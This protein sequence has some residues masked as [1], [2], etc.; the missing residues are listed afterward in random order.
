[1][2]TLRIYNSENCPTE[3]YHFRYSVYVEEMHRP[4]SDADHDNKLIKDYLDETGHH[5]VV[6]DEG[7]IVGCMRVNFLRDGSYGKYWDFYKLDEFQNWNPQ[8]SSICTRLMVQKEYRKSAV[9]KK[10]LQFIYAYGYVNDIETCIMDCNKPL[11]R[12][13]KKFGYRHMFDTSHEEYGDVSIMY[14]D[15]LDIDYL[16]DLSSPF[17]EAYDQLD[18]MF[19]HTEFEKIEVPI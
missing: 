15:L 1:M 16:R 6:L 12:F 2:I 14:L 4:Q 9:T 10:L 19:P 8:K 13:F 7:K 17:A 5:A 11:F 3:L 18:Q